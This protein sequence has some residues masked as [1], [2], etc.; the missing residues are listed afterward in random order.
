MIARIQVA[1]VLQSHALTARRSEDA[2]GPGH[3]E[4]ACQCSIE[5]QNESPAHV[6]LYPLI[7][8]LY[9]EMPPLS[10]PDRSVRNPVSF[11]E[12]GLPVLIDPFHNWNELKIMR[13]EFIAEEPIDVQGMVGVFRIDCA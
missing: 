9:Q 11:L 4:P 3:A 1:I 6:P 2:D 7:K 5:I 13:I 8:N 12:A 10:G